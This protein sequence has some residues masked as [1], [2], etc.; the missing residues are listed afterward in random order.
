MTGA[1]A[2]MAVPPPRTSGRPPRR[3]Q[4]APADAG[5]RAPASG[6]AAP[7]ALS[8]AMRARLRA[9]VHQLLADPRLDNTTDP[10]RLAAVVLMARTPESTGRVKTRARELARWLGCSTSYI[11]SVVLPGLRHSGAVKVSTVQGEFGQDTGLECSVLPLWEARGKLGSALRLTRKELAVLFHLVEALFAPGW[12]HRDGSVTPAGLLGERTG[13]GAATD[14]LALLLLALE[15]R[16]SGR[17]RQCGGTVDARRGRSATTVARLLGCTPAAG[18]RVLERLEDRGLVR[19]VRAASVSGLAHRTRLLLPAVAA[20]HGHR[21]GADERQEDCLLAEGPVL[22]D[23]DAAAGP[24]GAQN[25][26]GKPQVSGGPAPRISVVAEPDVEAA[27]HPDHP[28]VVRVGG[29]VEV[30]DGFSGYGRQGTGDRPERAGARARRG[31]LRGD[32]QDNHHISDFSTTKASAWHRAAAPAPPA[33]AE[34]VLGGAARPLWRRIGRPGAQ[35]RVLRA[36]RDELAAVQALTGP[37]QA[38]PA[39]AKRVEARLL[40]AGGPR[41]VADPVGWLI[42]RGLPQRRSCSDPACDDGLLLTTGGPCPLCQL[43]ITD[44]RGDRQAAAQ[45]AADALGPDAAPE[46]LRAARERI[47]RSTVWDRAERQARSAAI[48]ADRRAAIAEQRAADTAATGPDRPPTMVACPECGTEHQD[49]EVCPLCREWAAAETAVRE[50][51]V[52]A[53]AAASG[54]FRARAA[55][56]VEAECRSAM[57]DAANHVLAAGGTDLTAAVAAR[58]TAETHQAGLRDL[59]LT[60]LAQGEIAAAEA[61]QAQQTELAAPHPSRAAAQ[62]AADQAAAHAREETARHLLAR[63]LTDAVQRTEPPA[64]AGRP[65]P[66]P[67]HEEPGMRLRE[68]I[69]ARRRTV[70][71]R[72]GSSRDRYRNSR[73]TDTEVETNNPGNETN[74]RIS[75]GG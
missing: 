45:R 68:E 59:A 71:A 46:Q 17:V 54:P 26:E 24:S 74:V 38:V 6:P 23:P 40:D 36:I 18:E 51:V 16:E 5:P 13:R 4:P 34:A 20:A 69:A 41:G 9:A 61:R 35:R 72:T 31:P 19:R 60:V 22:A 29:V 66:A 30:S 14:R 15:A 42:G 32:Q 7:L 1:A 57:C 50:A 44:R 8:R 10:V 27:L 49:G 47:L 37:N 43:R 65:A 48:A 64:P 73:L 53:E 25:V 33:L 70:R 39:L 62:A 55:E 52:A 28:R 75:V 56:Q 58:M 11:A 67:L 21:S 3:P 63:H 12:Q 2:V